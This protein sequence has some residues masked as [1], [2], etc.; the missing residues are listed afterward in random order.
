MEDRAIPRDVAAMMV[1]RYLRRQA[2]KDAK[3]LTVWANGGTFR[4]IAQMGGPSV[5][6]LR[7]AVMQALRYMQENDRGA[8]WTEPVPTQRMRRW[9]GTD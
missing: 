2:H 6:A 7:R 3:W 1:K 5:R 8:E 4:T 9:V